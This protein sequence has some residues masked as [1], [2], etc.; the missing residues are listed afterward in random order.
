[1]PSRAYLAR[2][3]LDP[4]SQRQTKEQ[5]HSSV[6]CRLQEDSAEQSSDTHNSDEEEDLAD[7]GSNRESK[8]ESE[9]NKS[10]FELP[11]EVGDG[12]GKTVSDEFIVQNYESYTMVK[13]Q[14]YNS[15]FV[16]MQLIM[17]SLLF[18]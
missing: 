2:T 17:C 14:V 1:M 18:L 10:E 12:F 7:I 15:I 11:A 13:A 5:L 3:I 9:M 6:N 16:C 8:S 4:C